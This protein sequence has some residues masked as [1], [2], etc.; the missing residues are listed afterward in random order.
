MMLI[1][2]F[3]ENSTE[4]GERDKGRERERMEVISGAVNRNFVIRSLSP[5]YTSLNT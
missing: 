4:N 3:T 1:F 5:A 2:I